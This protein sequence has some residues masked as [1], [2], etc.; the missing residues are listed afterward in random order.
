[1]VFYLGTN[2]RWEVSF[3]PLP[4]DPRESFSGSLSTGG[5][6]GPRAGLD[7]VEKS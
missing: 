7:D 3:M 5:K 1:M 6:V 2:W 4:I